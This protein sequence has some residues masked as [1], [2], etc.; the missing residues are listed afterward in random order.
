MCT[1]Q[2]RNSQQ[3]ALKDDANDGI[4]MQT[5]PAE[6]DEYPELWSDL[7]SKYS[8]GH[9]SARLESKPLKPSSASPTSRRHDDNSLFP[10]TSSA[11]TS[12]STPNSGGTPKST[13][14]KAGIPKSAIAKAGIKSPN[15][16]SLP[17]SGAGS[18]A[19]RSLPPGSTSGAPLLD[20]HCEPVSEYDPVTP[21]FPLADSEISDIRSS[22]PVSTID[23]PS[24]LRQPSDMPR[25]LDS[26]DDH[27]I[28]QV[29]HKHAQK[30]KIAGLKRQGAGRIWKIE[31]LDFIN[32][33]REIG[34]D[35]S[36]LLES[37]IRFAWTNLSKGDIHFGEMD[38][39]AKIDY[40][41]FVEWWRAVASRSRGEGVEQLQIAPEVSPIKHAFDRYDLDS[42][43][44]LN[45]QE[46]SALAQS[47]DKEGKLTTRMLRSSFLE[48]D[49]DNDGLIGFDEFA[50][51]W[52]GDNAFLAGNLPF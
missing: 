10:S 49:V 42:D 15:S 33:V 52:K 23:S 9:P 48:L 6:V 3:D 26:V 36:I 13:S 24:W 31:K 14:P 38:L 5:Y 45:F 30:S 46:F 20:S 4:E 50:F 8:M 47:T 19:G 25:P 51:A 35:E 18:D 29:F 43:G 11:G 40:D 28:G 16:C 17:Q 39:C 22:E 32:M 27:L 12:Q 41:E 44:F 37:E 2:A 21:H 7:P 1:S 34:A